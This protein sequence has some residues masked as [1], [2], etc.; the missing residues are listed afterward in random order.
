MQDTRMSGGGMMRRVFER[1]QRVD[2]AKNLMG[3]AE[4]LS[5]SG[6]HMAIDAGGLR[7]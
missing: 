3:T 6:S 4:W 5:W 1:S 7:L 2:E